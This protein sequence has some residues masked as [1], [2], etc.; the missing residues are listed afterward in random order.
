[1]KKNFTIVP[2]EVLGPSQLSLSARCLFIDLV[3]YCGQK[4]FCFPSQRTL[5][6]D[7]CISMR[8]IRNLLKELESEGLIMSIRSGYNKSNT[9]KVARE[10]F[11]TKDRNSGSYQMRSVI[12][13]HRGNC[14]PHNITYPKTRDKSSERNMQRLSD[15]MVAHGI[16]I[17]RRQ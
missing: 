13:L 3:R 9:Y 16:R 15:Y 8:H 7:L 17:K 5:A 14:V 10:V 4:D 11:I 6:S 12:P 2:N 1:M